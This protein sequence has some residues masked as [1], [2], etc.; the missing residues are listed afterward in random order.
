MRKFNIEKPKELRN[1]QTLINFLDWV[2]Q[3]K[4]FQKIFV[5]DIFYVSDEEL[6]ELYQEYLNAINNK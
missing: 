3:K 1:G 2:S 4:E 5:A 6:E